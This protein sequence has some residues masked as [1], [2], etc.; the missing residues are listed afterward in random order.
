MSNLAPISII[1]CLIAAA[2]GEAK[3][4]WSSYT[5]K[6][7]SRNYN[8]HLSTLGCQNPIS[9]T[10]LVKCWLHTIDNCLCP[11]RI[12]RSLR[13]C[14]VLL[15]P[16]V[17]IPS[18]IPMYVSK[19]M[20]SLQKSRTKVIWYVVHPLIMDS[21]SNILMENQVTTGDKFLKKF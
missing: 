3:M 14:V 7:N 12:F 10:N 17:L 6:M 15:P 20:L 2:I 18:G 19:L 4:P 11:Y 13:M 21:T 9:S 8:T 1:A 5:T 16:L